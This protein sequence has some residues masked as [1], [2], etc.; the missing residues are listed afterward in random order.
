[1]AGLSLRGSGWQSLA[2]PLSCDANVTCVPRADPLC[3]GA[4]TVRFRGGNT[5]AGYRKPEGER[6]VVPSRDYEVQ[7]DLPRLR[8]DSKGDTQ[9]G[10]HADEGAAQ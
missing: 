6:G 4:V 1:M 8:I 7:P 9:N 2:A 3:L 10:G 5:V